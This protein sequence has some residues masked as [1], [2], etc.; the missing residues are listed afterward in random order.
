MP[1][2]RAAAPVAAGSYT[3]TE[4][5]VA[6][7][8]TSYDNCAAVVIANGGSA[9][10]TITNND[11]QSAPTLSTLIVPNDQATLNN[12]VAGAASPGSITFALY[13]PDDTGCTGTAK[14]TKTIT[15]I[16]TGG[17]YVT[18]NTT[19]AIAATDTGVWRWK[20]TYSGDQFNAPVE[21]PCGTERF[22]VA[23]GAE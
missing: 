20:V 15:G 13:G 2:G 19:F 12:F 11:N 22:T 18:D 5:A 10:C 16:V 8:T 7:Y 6:G 3:V 23:Y 4:P 1:R 17:T 21:S 9:T 14:Y